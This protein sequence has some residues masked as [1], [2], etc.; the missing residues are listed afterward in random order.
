MLTPSRKAPGPLLLALLLGGGIVGVVLL[1]VER[2]RPPATRE[3]ERSEADGSNPAASVEARGSRGPWEPAAG[4]RL[5]AVR[6]EGERL[7]GRP[8]EVLPDARRPAADPAR[9]ARTR[10]EARARAAIADEP[11]DRD[12]ILA[13]LAE[14]F[15]AMNLSDRPAPG[16]LED[17]ADA[18]E[19]L[20]AARRVLDRVPP[21]RASAEILAAQRLELSDALL[22]F[23]EITGLDPAEL[24]R[25]LEPEEGV[26]ADVEPGV[27]AADTSNGPTRGGSAPPELLEELPER[28]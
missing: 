3:P 17:L 2:G 19:R 21:S 14:A 28:P 4:R 20:R 26:T 6:E 10:A 7:P 1:V 15:E 11:L 22:R 24:T 5:A 9:A 27:D 25:L 12:R 23:E 13:L 18:V 16:D 8:E